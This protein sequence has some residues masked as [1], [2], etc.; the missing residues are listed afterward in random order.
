M[1]P[2]R[3]TATIESLDGG[4]DSM[5]IKEMPATFLADVSIGCGGDNT[6]LL[7]AVLFLDGGGGGGGGGWKVRATE[8]LVGGQTF[9]ESMP[10]VREIVDAI[11][12]VDEGLK[13]ERMLS[14]DKTFDM[15]KDEALNYLLPAS[16]FGEGNDLFVGLGWECHDSVDLDASVVAFNRLKSGEIQS[17]E[18]CY[19]NKKTILDGSI[20]HKGDN[21]TGA[22]KGD[23]EVILLDVTKIPAH[24]NELFFTVNVYTR[25]K[26]FHDVRDAYIRLVACRKN[27]ELARFKLGKSASRPGL[28]FLKMSRVGS[29]MWKIEPL[30]WGTYG[31][32]ATTM[33]TACKDGPNGT[34]SDVIDYPPDAGGGDDQRQVQQAGGGCCVIA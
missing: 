17:E 5:G 23:D 10:E 7:L 29:K 8:K 6:G 28:I 9:V 1:I 19:Y 31:R 25:M 16:L 2:S 4:S 30:G 13:S 15:R 21:T 12:D 34:S 11:L 3:A 22:G 20:R 26:S 27:H 14:M 33:L 24:I 18:T 32:T